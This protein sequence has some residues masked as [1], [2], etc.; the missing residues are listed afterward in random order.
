ML[1][2]DPNNE[3]AKIEIGMTHLEKGDFAA[4]ETTL[5]EAAQSVS[6]SREVFYNLGEVKFAKGETDEA[7]KCVSARRGHG[8][9]LGQTALQDRPRPPAEGRHQE[10]HRD[11]GKGDRRRSEF[12]GSGTGEGAD[13]AVEE[14]IEPPVPES[15]SQGDGRFGN[16]PLEWKLEGNC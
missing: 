4:A 8:S 1:E 11:D 13:R 14:G 5:L 10:R 12:A 7:M 15:G 9:Q 6:A 3:R 16:R 2:A